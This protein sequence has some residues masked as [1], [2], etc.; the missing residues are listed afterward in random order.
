MVG[1]RCVEQAR[2]SGAADAAVIRYDQQPHIL[3][4][5]RKESSFTALNETQVTATATSLALLR[6][7][8]EHVAVFKEE[9]CDADAAIAPG[10]PGV[11]EKP[12]RLHAPGDVGRLNLY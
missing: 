7:K 4:M 12:G 3:F 2:K 11:L 9:I 8:R 10:E 1:R 5:G 6:N